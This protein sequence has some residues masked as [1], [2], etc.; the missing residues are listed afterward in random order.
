[1]DKNSK[2]N[3]HPACSCR[4]CR[5]GAGTCFGQFVHA[6][7]NRAIRRTY[8]QELAAVVRDGVRDVEPVIVSTGYTD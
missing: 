2:R 3:E 4:S 6:K 1:M 5:R 7:V 8:R